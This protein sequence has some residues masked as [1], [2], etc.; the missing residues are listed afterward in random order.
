[1]GMDVYGE[2][3]SSETGKYFRNNVWWW[4]PLWD[5]ICK[6]A[7]LDDETRLVGHYNDGFLINA[8]TATL[9][10][11]LL[12]EEIRSGRTT[13]FELQY[14]MAQDETPEEPC[15]L[16]RGTGTRKDMKVANG[17]N[18]CQGTGKVKPFSTW[19]PF[20]TENVQKFATFARESGGFRIS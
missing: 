16:C 2:N 6:V 10:A 13:A 20:S 4:R 15:E 8:A 19:Y 5:Y 14:Q 18:K 9:I 3:P 17:C 11:D 7:K 1:M 12:D